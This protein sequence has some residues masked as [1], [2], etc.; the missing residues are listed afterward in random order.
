MAGIF[1]METVYKKS[2]NFFIVL[3]FIIGCIVIL[4]YRGLFQASLVQDVN[5]SLHAE[6][7][8]ESQA[9]R[10]TC[11]QKGVYQIWQEPDGETFH[12]LCKLDSGKIGDRIIRIANGE[13]H[14]KTAFIPKNGEWNKVIKW[15][16][17]KGATR[18]TK[19]I[20]GVINAELK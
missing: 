20:E 15:L 3:F 19:P 10:N 7:H 5:N 4:T 12:L 8:T 13:K 14:E 17:N 11:N 16:E 18:Y 9:I 1:D 2:S 6:W